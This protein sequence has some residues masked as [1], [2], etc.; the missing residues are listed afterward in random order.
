MKKKLPLFLKSLFLISFAFGL[1][2]SHLESRHAI[3]AE[4]A[5]SPIVITAANMGIGASYGT[6]TATIDGVSFESSD[7]LLSNANMQFKASSGILKNTTAIPGEILTISF[8]Q[9]GTARSFTVNAGATTSLTSQGNQSTKDMSWDLSGKGFKFFSITRGSNA[10]YVPSITITFSSKSLSSIAVSQ[11]PIKTLYNVGESFSTLGMKIRAT[12]DDLSVD[13]NYTNYSISPDRTLLST[14]TFITITSKDNPSLTTNVPIT[15]AQYIG[16]SAVGPTKTAYL[17]GEKLSTAGLVVTANFDGGTPRV[18]SSS[19]YSTSIANG[20]SVTSETLTITAVIAGVTHT[21]NIALTLYDFIGLEV[22]GTYKTDYLFY[23]PLDLSEMIVTALFE[24]NQTKVLEVGEYGLS[25]EDGSPIIAPIAEGITVSATIG[26]TTHAVN[27]NPITVSDFTGIIIAGTY[28]TEYLYG[29]TLDLSGLTVTAQYQNNHTTEGITSYV[30]E[31]TN[32]TKLYQD[33][34]DGIDISYF[35]GGKTYTVQTAPIVVHEI[36][37]IS[38]EGSYKTSYYPGEAFSKDGMLVDVHYDNGVT[39]PAVSF[40]TEV[41]SGSPITQ[42]YE[43]GIT[44]TYVENGQSFEAKTSAIILASLVS[45]EIT[46]EPTKLN[47]KFGESFANSGLVVKA[48]YS[49][50]SVVADYTNYTVSLADGTDM[51]NLGNQT[52]NVVSKENPLISDSFLVSVTNQGTQ[53]LVAT[54][55]FISEY[56]EGSGNNKAIEI[57]NGTGKDVDFSKYSVALYANGTSSPNS[58]LNLSGILKNGEVYVISNSSADDGIKLLSDIEH[59]VTFFGG[60]DA[61][62]LLKEGVLIDEFGTIGKDPGASWGSGN[63]STENHTLVRKSSI[64]SGSLYETTFDPSVE[65]ESYPVDTFLHLGSHS[66]ASYDVD[67]AAQ[68]QAYADYFLNKVE[69]KAGA[70]HD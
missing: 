11:S 20:A 21:T 40:S 54:D 7:I 43:S 45:I 50:N 8:S 64:I 58:T 36:D 5:S 60:D 28:K 69:G 6:K 3:V 29:E 48:T 39:K 49:N 62:G 65:W 35:L 47:Y 66:L 41:S 59:G 46:S 27:T 15:V 44:I 57:F 10:A 25:T 33:Y 30:Q 61:I 4:A 14:D 52:V 68:A 19:E 67:N 24:N 38:V 17:R 51:V 42:A 31:I 2:N 26:G 63:Y 56:I 18:L 9:T 16:L 55:L 34:P 37:H 32:G 23:Q 13:E 53:G 70:C 12:Y 22:S 1:A